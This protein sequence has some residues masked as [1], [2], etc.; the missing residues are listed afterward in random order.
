[1][2]CY[3]PIKAYKTTDG[4]VVFSELSR[5]DICKTLELACGQCYGCKLERSRQWAVRCMHE[6]AMHKRNSFI[7]LTYSDE[8]LPER[9]LQHKDFQDFMKRLRE[10]YAPHRVR[11]YMAGEYGGTNPETGIID[12]GRYRPHYHACLFGHDWEDKLFHTTTASGEDI[13]TSKELEKLWP[14]GFSSTA[15][16]TFQSAAYIARYCLKKITGD[17]AEEVYKR[18]DYLGEY[19]L[20]EE[21]NCM[22]L[23]PG[24]GKT[25]MQKFESDLYTYDYLIVN[26]VKT[27]IP[28][29][30][31]KIFQDK[32]PDRYEEIQYEREKQARKYIQDQTPE[33]LAVKET[34]AKARTQSLKRKI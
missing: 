5:Y 16:V 32:E 26:G 2:P 11:F 1:M 30:Y 22:S 7:T 28:R 4:S 27:K 6:A 19:Q 24:I 20:P 8:H 15:N 3:K 13:Y 10:K 25:W 14:W 31:D 17:M 18:F 9:G 33:R 21:Y 12:G 29:Y 34:V 23:K